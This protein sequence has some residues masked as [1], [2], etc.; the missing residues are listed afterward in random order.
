MTT[1]DIDA[2]IQRALARV[3]TSTEVSL[4][5]G[6]PVLDSG[7][8]RLQHFAGPT[9]GALPGVTLAPNEGLG[10]RSVALSRTMAVND[11]FQSDRITHRYDPII[12]AEGLRSLVATPIVLARR[13]VAVLYGA[14]RGSQLI[15]DRI[16]DSIAHEARALEHELLARTILITREPTP[17]QTRLREQIRD[18]HSD[19]RL[20][21]STVDQPELRAALEQITRR[22]AE[23]DGPP[24]TELSPLT[25]RETDIVT[26]VATGRSNQQIAVTL[27][28]S[29]HTVKSYMKAVMF[30][31]DATSRLEAVVNAR[32]AGIVP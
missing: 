22:L 13:S 15:G 2:A 17:E 32:R 18:A 6:G 21:A 30:K 12:R 20:L 14:F 29:L 16:R 24:T 1:N 11:Y 27:G 3:R 7:D 28:L 31:L 25:S 9:T 19:L 5:F 4:A 8:V 23:A 10:G 26:L